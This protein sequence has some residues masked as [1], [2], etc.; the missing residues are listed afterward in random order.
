MT[1]PYFMGIDQGTQR[2]K[3]AL[4]NTEGKQIY[5]T[6]SPYETQHP[7]QGWAEQNP[8][9][10][11]A[12]LKICIGRCLAE[13][14]V[15]KE[16]IKA[17]GV[18]ATSATVLCC[19]QK[20]EPLDD[21]II[22]MDVRAYEEAKLIS[23]T[24]H[25]VL[26]YAGGS[27]SEEWMVPKALWLKRNKPELYR[28][29]Q[30]IVESLD[31]LTFKLIGSWT[32]SLCNVTNS[33]NYV[34]ALGGWTPEF[35]EQIELAEILEKWPQ[36]V[37]PIGAPVGYLSSQSAADLGL[38]KN[39]LVV[40]GGIDSH[41]GMLGMG[42]VDLGEL[43]FT[44]GTSNVH[45]I[46]SRESVFVPGL[47]GPYQHAII[48]DRWLLEGGQTTSAIILKW[49]ENSLTQN[50]AGPNNFYEVFDALAREIPPGS[51]GLVMLDTWQGN[52]T[53]WRDTLARGALWGLSLKHSMAHIYRATMESIA[54]GTRNII[55]TMQENRIEIKTIRVS[56]GGA[57]N[58]FW[59]QIFS[60]VCRLPVSVPKNTEATI[61]GAAIAAAVGAGY[62][63]SIIEACRSMVQITQTI[64][65]NLNHSQ[66]YD[67]YYTKYLETYYALKDLMHEVS[68]KLV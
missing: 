52:R 61:F 3:V 15:K 36:E 54:Y 38:E 14:G 50:G 16:E 18:A 24:Q 22:W 51:E 56:G 44:I 27:E 6:A 41:M 2:L 19:D 42:A 63:P 23:Q 30:H 39:T 55:D 17:I 12:A 64:S 47:W 60:D 40:E 29:A 58:L 53:P 68:L 5:L 4:F 46:L 37:L 11:W 28:K 33:W 35:F 34:P 57:Q 32:A 49:L 7:H 66:A 25:P 21:A 26:K 59:L 1:A 13:S 10:W 65:P 20:G 45:L 43:A 8:N 67:F 31:W 9:D 48:K 62:Y